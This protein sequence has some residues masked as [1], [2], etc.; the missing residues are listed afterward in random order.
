M[1][2]AKDLDRRA[3]EDEDEVFDIIDMNVNVFTD[4]VLRR[5]RYA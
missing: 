5:K 2:L 3:D 4:R 1:A